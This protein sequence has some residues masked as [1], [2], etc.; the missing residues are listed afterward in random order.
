MINE[1][2]KNGIIG[3]ILGDAMGV[4]LEFSKRR[5][6]DNKVIDMLEYGSH[7]L[8]KGSWSDDSSMVIATMKS[9]IDNKGKID[10][11][12]IMNNFI[13]WA[14]N[15]EFTPNGKTFGIGRTTLRAL[16]NY[17]SN[18]IKAINCGLDSI[19]DNGNGSLMRILPIIY[20]CYYNNSNDNEIY[21]IIK[22][23]SSLTHSNNI[24]ILGC[25][26]YT[27]Y[28]IQ[29][30]KGNNKIDSY[31]YIK[32]Y[33]YNMFDNDVLRYCKR[34]LKEDISKLSID[35]I[36]SLGFVVDTL[37]AVI[38]CF[39][40]S[41]SYDDSIIKAINLGNDADTIGALVGALSGI[42]YSDINI[43]WIKEIKR[44]DY[45]EDIIKEFSNV[46]N[47]SNL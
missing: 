44:I 37:E 35:D 8:E 15:G 27:L 16:Y 33:D 20:Y 46:L 34:L 24:S 23:T 12:D 30:I 19:K 39:L 4:P 11:E 17:K 40:N 18:N 3:F 25:Y 2:V 14:E 45:I 21:E 10:Y 1:I 6:A 38:W 9:I 26:I 22:N 28:C 29:L 41:N 7:N 13:K 42:Y 31:K 32:N 43:N 47:Y 36:S 5:N